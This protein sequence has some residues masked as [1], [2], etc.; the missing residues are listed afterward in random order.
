MLLQ[1]E[2]Y[3]RSVQTQS[4][5][6]LQD[7]VLTI[8]DIEPVYLWAKLTY[9][10]QFERFVR[11]LSSLVKLDCPKLKSH[12]SKYSIKELLEIFVV[13]QTFF[14]NED[15]CKEPA[16]CSSDLIAAVLST[17][18]AK[19]EPLVKLSGEAY[20][21]FKRLVKGVTGKFISETFSS[22]K[23]SEDE[24]LVVKVITPNLIIQSYRLDDH[25]DDLLASI[26]TS[27]FAMLYK[28][29]VYLKITTSL[30]QTKRWLY[31]EPAGQVKTL[32]KLLEVSSV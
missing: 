20:K 5:N 26:E 14:Y 13:C 30:N 19:G 4:S 7:L 16:K 1:F 10:R 23:P 21:C 17:K 11:V 8:F 15:F 28:D 3:L 22:L 18:L 31:K 6:T 2:D 25:T 27:D 29:L 9:N 24:I 12:L 32:I